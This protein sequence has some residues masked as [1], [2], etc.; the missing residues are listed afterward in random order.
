[1]YLLAEIDVPWVADG[2]RDRGH[3]RDE[4]QSLFRNAVRKSGSPWVAIQG[5]WYQR[6]G[7]AVAAV[8]RLRAEQAT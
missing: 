1:L 4:M 8:D 6:W 5:T 3:L 2:I 7:L